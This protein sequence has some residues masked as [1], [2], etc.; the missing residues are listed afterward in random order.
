MTEEK[1]Q[2]LS[3]YDFLLEDEVVNAVIN[4]EGNFVTITG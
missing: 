4:H 3:D 1:E 2:Q